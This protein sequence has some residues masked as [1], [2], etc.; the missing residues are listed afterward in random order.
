M[1]QLVGGEV[2][3][4]AR[5]NGG[6]QT[7]APERFEDLP[8]AMGAKGRSRCRACGAPSTHRVQLAVR[9]ALPQQKGTP[10]QVASHVQE[11]CERHAVKLF[12]DV[13][14]VMR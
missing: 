3:P 2:V 10:P 12:V 8:D 9:Q 1:S 4:A 14:K 11:F 13:R 5:D 7:D 6:G